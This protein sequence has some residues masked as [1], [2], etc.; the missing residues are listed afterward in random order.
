[1]H[2]HNRGAV[3][4]RF[5]QQSLGL[6]IIGAHHDVRSGISG[7]RGVAEEHGRALLVVIRIA[8]HA[9]QEV[10]LVDRPHRRTADPDIV[11]RR[12]Q[13]IHA[14]HVLVAQGVQH[15]GMNVGV[16]FQQREQVM[17][18]RLHVVNLSGEQGVH[19]RLVILDG[20]PLH[21]VHVDGLASGHPI[22]RLAA[23]LVVGILD[24]HGAVAGLPLILLEDEGAG[25]R[26]V[27]DLLVRRSVGDTLGHDERHIGTWLG[28]GVQHKPKW[29]FQYK[30]NGVAVL[31]RQALRVLHEHLAHAVLLAP[32]VERGHHVCRRHG[33]A[34]VEHQPVAQGHRVSELVVAHRVVSHHLRLDVQVAVERKQRVIDH[35]P[36][37]AGHV[38]RGPDRV[39]DL[40][41]RVHHHSEGGFCRH[42]VCSEQ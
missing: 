26:V 31:C 20:N 30:L 25:T 39:N 7:Q 23:S 3:V 33:G 5:L 41:V 4:T 37:V 27:L 16:G 34:V 2:Q 24:E 18:H 12:V 15:S 8:D 36:V 38:R 14:V 42:R 21:A 28:Q 29:L 35:V 11:K 19:C 9:L 1:M 32:A 6:R 17:R 40:E 10:L 13:P 22:R